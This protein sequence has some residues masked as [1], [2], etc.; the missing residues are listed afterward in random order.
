MSESKLV[1]SLLA[2]IFILA[3]LALL[4][5]DAQADEYIR[6]KL[7]VLLHTS[8]NEAW[9]IRFLVRTGFNAV[10]I[11]LLL[12]IIYLIHSNRQYFKFCVA[13]FTLLF[14]LNIG[15][16]M[17]NISLGAVALSRTAK[18]LYS[19]TTQPFLALVLIAAFPIFKGKTTT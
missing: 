9:R 13:V 16:T 4:Y 17:L 6:Q 2:G 1:K 8:D 3:Y 19:L 18:Y 11:N 5:Y 7:S 12:I 10:I 15:A 14:L